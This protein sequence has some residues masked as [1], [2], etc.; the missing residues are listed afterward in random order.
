MKK[1]ELISVILLFFIAFVFGNKLFSQVEL[2]QDIFTAGSSLEPIR[3]KVLDNQLY[4]RTQD[5]GVGKELWAYDGNTAS[6]LV[7]TRPGSGSFTP[8]GYLK[9]ENNIYFIANDC[10]H[11]EEMC[12]YN[13][14][15]YFSA[16]DGIHG[17][18]LWMDN[19]G[20]TSLEN[21]TIDDLISIYPNPYSYQIYIEFENVDFFR[22]KCLGFCYKTYSR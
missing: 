6:M 13:G 11:G 5:Y 8:S 12:M 10:I 18:E 7:D 21:S 4:F 17:R 20:A 22:S 9:V 16:D 19:F 14:K 15:L 1:V 3:F 2:V